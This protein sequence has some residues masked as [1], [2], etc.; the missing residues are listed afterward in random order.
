MLKLR[1]KRIGRKHSP[2]FRLVIMKNN[3]KRNGYSIDEV[4]YY[5]P[6]NKKCCLNIKKIHN[7]LKKGVKPTKIAASLLQS[8]IKQYEL[9]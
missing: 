5:N 3:S 7:W 8:Y 9:I 1:L 4:G 2:T 6:S